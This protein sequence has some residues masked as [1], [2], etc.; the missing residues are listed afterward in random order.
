[1]TKGQNIVQCSE[2][3]VRTVRDRVADAMVLIPPNDEAVD[4]ML[5]RS[6]TISVMV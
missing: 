3:D 4:L 5:G 2:K 6:N 1:M